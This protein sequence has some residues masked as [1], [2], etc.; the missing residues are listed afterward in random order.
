MNI[1]DIINNHTVYIPP[2]PT[3]KNRMYIGYND[4]KTKSTPPFSV[5]YAEIVQYAPGWVAG[6]GRFLV[7][8]Y[9][10]AA[11]LGRRVFSA[12]YSEYT[13]GYECLFGNHYHAIAAL[14]DAI[15]FHPLKATPY[16]RDKAN[17]VNYE[18]SHD[19]D[20]QNPVDVIRFRS[21]GLILNMLRE[22]G[23]V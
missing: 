22:H 23:I 10:N 18:W 3:N 14:G 15:A 20:Y 4:K 16:I 13:G 21:V 7:R 11:L 6:Y 2:Q 9:Y 5:V 19:L 12:G 1:L 8:A 17:L